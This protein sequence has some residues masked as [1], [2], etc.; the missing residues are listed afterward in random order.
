M[1]YQK[2]KKNLQKQNSKNKSE[3]YADIFYQNKR[4]WQK[5]NEVILRMFHVSMCVFLQK[6]QQKLV[7]RK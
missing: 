4:T 1:R 3:N 6:Q 7:L 5:K 2:Q